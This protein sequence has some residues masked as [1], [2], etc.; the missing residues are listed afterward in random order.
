MSR[1]IPWSGNAGAWFAAAKALGFPVGDTP[2]LVE[3]LA[4][5]SPHEQQIRDYVSTAAAKR[6]E[7]RAAAEQKTG[8]FTGAYA[9]NPA[10]GKA[11]MRYDE[12]WYCMPCAIDC[13]T[14]AVTVSIPYLLR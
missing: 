2:A 6:A 11:H 3:R 7:E 12:C 13:P 10:N 1:N 4:Q 9:I 5:G 14:K 8:V